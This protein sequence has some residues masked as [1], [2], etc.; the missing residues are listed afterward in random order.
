ML[1]NMSEI[2]KPT[3]ENHFAVPAF[4]TSSN[5]ILTASIE[6]A[7]ELNAPVI[8]EIHPD[9][10]RFVKESF[11]AAVRAEAN[12]AK[13]PVCIHLD[14]GA[15]FADTMR[16]I[17]CGFT[18]VMIDGSALPY[19]ENVALAKKV[20]EAAHAA[21]VSVEAELGTIGTMEGNEIHYT[22]PEEAK[23]FVASTGVD[24]LAVAIGTRHGLYPKGLTP[25]LELDLLRRLRE[26]IDIP[27][28]LHGGSDNPDSEIEQACLIGISKIN[29]S[30][31]IKKA[32][33]V[34]CREVLAD[35]SLREP[36]AIYPPCIEE[37]KKV[38]RHKFR[39]FHADGRAALY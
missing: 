21:G 4:N 29:I 35:E 2:L 13:V 28:V 24:T 19:D 26:A 16:A 22:Q 14:H 33:Y 20:A 15:S 11:V 8:I 32:F 5:M 30:S 34:K 1:V 12:R 7:E 6:V 17:G 23:D 27:L 10:L 31:D 18:S 38:M 3:L 9:E 25:H 36:N 39:L 37:M